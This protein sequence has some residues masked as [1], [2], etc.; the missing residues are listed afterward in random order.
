MA[1]SKR[2]TGGAA[3]QS[4]VLTFS[5]SMSNLVRHYDF[6]DPH[7]CRKMSDTFFFVAF[8]RPFRCQSLSDAFPHV[9]RT[10]ANR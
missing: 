4:P 2:W 9:V 8:V 3:D 6:P 10:L 7:R 5:D 1:N